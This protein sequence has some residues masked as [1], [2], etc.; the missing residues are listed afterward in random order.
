MKIAGSTWKGGREICS[1]FNNGDLVTIETEDEYK[2]VKSMIRL[3]AN[4]FDNKWHIGLEKKG[5]N[6]VWV[7]GTP[8]TASH[9]AQSQPTGNDN[10]AVMSASGELFAEDWKETYGVICEYEPGEH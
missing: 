7:N 4:S 6:W 3:A 8:L 1:G 2:F 10:Y 5:N 9:W